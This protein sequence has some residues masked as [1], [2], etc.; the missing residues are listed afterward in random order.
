VTALAIDHQQL[1]E[2]ARP[3]EI[4]PDLGLAEAPPTPARRGIEW[5]LNIAHHPL[6]LCAAL[7]LRRASDAGESTRAGRPCPSPSPV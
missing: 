7:V 1:P 5:A 2:G 3:A 6:G 4:D